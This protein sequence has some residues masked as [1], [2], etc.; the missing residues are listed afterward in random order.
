MSTLE[1]HWFLMDVEASSI[2]FEPSKS[3]IIG[4]K[5]PAAKSVARCPAV[6]DRASR[7]F[8][9]PAPIDLR[10]RFG[11][12]LDKPEIRIVEN[13]SSVTYN[14][15]RNNFLIQDRAEWLSPSAPVVQITTP[16]VF[17][18]KEPCFVNQVFPVEK[19]GL[20][21][22]Y[23]LIEGRFPIDKWLRPLSWAIEWVDTSQDV[24]I[25]RGQPW[26]SLFFDFEKPD[27]R[28]RL[29]RGKISS[30]DKDALF[31]TKDVTA[32]INGTKKLWS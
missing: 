18:A 20:G 24:I 17:K 6:L 28:A 8:S 32:Y 27:S 10:L 7:L 15:L 9:V 16:Y 11:G 5:N 23:R 21:E 14:K 30:A 1:V 3:T 31:A 12:T 4:N 29:K 26:F 19:I 2:Y 13:H 22:P 25:Q